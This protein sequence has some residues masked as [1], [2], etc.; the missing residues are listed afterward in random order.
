MKSGDLSPMFDSY[1]DIY[2]K[3]FPDSSYGAA[4]A[5]KKEL[6]KYIDGI[7]G[8]PA[9]KF[10]SIKPLI[11]NANTVESAIYLRVFLASHDIVCPEFLKNYLSKKL[12][13]D[14]Y[15]SLEGFIDIL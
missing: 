3:T 10:A 12:T 4:K 7:T 9:K 11:E 14:A 8:I 1:V 5:F 13:N 2:S 15:E 6:E